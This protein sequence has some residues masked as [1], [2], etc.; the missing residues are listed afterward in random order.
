MLFFFRNLL[1]QD[2]LRTAESQFIENDA[3]LEMEGAFHCIRQKV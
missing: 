1:R 2:I 3:T